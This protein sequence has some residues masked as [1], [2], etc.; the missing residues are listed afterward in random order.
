[1]RATDL[2]PL[3]FPPYMDHLYLL[4]YP[5]LIVIPPLACLV[6][7]LRIFFTPF[8]FTPFLYS[9]PLLLSSLFSKSMH[10]Y[11]EPGSDPQY[12]R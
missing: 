7:P 5:F 3:S 6:T 11:R 1:M 12:R 10:H 9:F 2:A 4:F 8:L